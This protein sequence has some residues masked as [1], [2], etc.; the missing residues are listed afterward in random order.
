[1]DV[2]RLARTAMV[3]GSMACGTLV[4]TPFITACALA[5]RVSGADAA[6]RLWSRALMRTF[7]VRREVIGAEHAAGLGACVILSSHR[8]HL[9]GPLLL[10]ALPLDFAFVIKRSLARIPVWGFGVTRAGYVAIDRHDRADSVAGFRRAASAIRAGRRVLV[11]PEGTRSKTDDFLP[12]KKGGAILAIEAGVPVL[13]VAVAG[14]QALLPSGSFTAAP[15]RAVVAIGKPIPTTG[16]TYD[17]RD[18]LLADV[19][20]E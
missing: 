15:G 9:D 5:G 16:L 18:R 14:T 13:P 8:S 10:C 1:M 4:L 12:F 20:A 3:Y 19:E 2:G 17:D 7:G 11:F 6:I